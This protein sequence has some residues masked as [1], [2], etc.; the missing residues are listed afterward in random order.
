[1]HTDYPHSAIAT[2]GFFDG[3]HKGHQYLIEQLR[4]LS[5]ERHKQ[6]AVITFAQHPRQVLNQG[7]QADLLTLSSE[8]QAL[9]KALNVDRCI[10]L[11]FTPELAKLSAKQFMQI[12][13]QDYC[14]D[15]L[16]V[17][18]DHRFGH[19]R[20]EGFSHYEEYGRELGMS[21]FQAKPYTLENGNPVSS[22]SIRKMLRAGQIREANACL[23]YSYTL[24]GKVVVGHQVGR[25]IGFPTANIQVDKDKLL[26]TDG[27]YAVKVKIADK[28]FGG[29]LSIGKRPTMDNGSDR[30]IE[31]HIFDFQQ[32]LYGKEITLS[33]IRRTREEIKFNTQEA[34]ISQLHKDKSQII[35]ILKETES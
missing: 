34:L 1:M 16:L 15:G 20:N 14:I 10:V 30:S 7:F 21:V 3:V 17:G 13:R 22:S 25:T 11:D 35:Q 18:Y 24:S 29:M 8:K 12:L 31:V 26:P 32:D 19:D 28:T 5:A 2:V 6:N 27:V 9:L 4:L 33:L 23:G